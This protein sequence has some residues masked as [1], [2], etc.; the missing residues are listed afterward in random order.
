MCKSYS[1]RIRCKI[2]CRVRGTYGHADF[3][4]LL[5]G[6]LLAQSFGQCCQGMLRGRVEMDVRYRYH[7]VA[8]GAV[9]VDHLQARMAFLDE[10]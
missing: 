3:G 10:G 2:H 9:D 6:Q 7:P 5:G 4:G 8:R 1:V